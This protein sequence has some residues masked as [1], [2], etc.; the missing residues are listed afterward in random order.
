MG[1]IKMKTHKSLAKRFKVTGTGKL[2]HWKAGKSHLLRKKSSKR[3]R[4]LSQTKILTGRTALKFK[5]VL[6]T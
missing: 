4:R 3:R 6:E 1:K 2:M 5:K